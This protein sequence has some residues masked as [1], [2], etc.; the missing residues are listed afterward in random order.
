MANPAQRY[1][2]YTVGWICALSTKRRAAMAMLDELHIA[3]PR[4][5]DDTNIYTFGS[6]GKHNVV[7]ACPTIGSA[8]LDTIFMVRMFP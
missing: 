1:S 5:S 3:L 6:I 4:P 8:A 7:V 2:N